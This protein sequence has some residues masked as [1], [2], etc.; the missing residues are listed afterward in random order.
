MR[1]GEQNRLKEISWR[2]LQNGSSLL[3]GLWI[4]LLFTLGGWFVGL[5]WAVKEIVDA[6][7]VPLRHSYS[8]NI[9]GEWKMTWT[10]E[11]STGQMLDPAGA[12]VATGYAGGNCGKNP[13]GKNNPQMQFMR[14]VGPLPQGVYTMGTPVAQSHLGPFAIPLTPAPDNV[15]QG[16]GS[17][18]IHG[19]TT[20]SGNASEGCIIM[21]R[22]IRQAMWDSG[23]HVVTVVKGD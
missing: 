12:V 5:G 15:M 13:E 14:C 23:D 19:D 22:A 16:R 8:D 18:F 17:F 6:W 7:S 1:A 21:P 4:W 10:F 20:P 2:L 9:G 11:Q 3:E